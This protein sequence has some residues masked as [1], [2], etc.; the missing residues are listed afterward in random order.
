M[1]EKYFLPNQKKTSFPHHLFN[2]QG[3]YIFLVICQ[4]LFSASS[5]RARAACVFIIS[6]S[7][8]SWGSWLVKGSTNPH[9]LSWFFCFFLR[10]A[11]TALS[12]RFSL[13]SSLGARAFHAMLLSCDALQLNIICHFFLLLQHS[14]RVH[15]Y[16]RTTHE[17]TSRCAAVYRCMRAMWVYVT[18]FFS[19]SRRQTSQ[20]R[21]RCRESTFLLYI[22]ALWWYASPIAG[23]HTYIYTAPERVVLNAKRLLTCALKTRLRCQ[24]ILN[25]CM[26]L[27]GS[28]KMRHQNPYSRSSTCKT[29]YF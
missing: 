26:T 28:R 19:P 2:K 13:F 1:R 4:E 12:Y 27:D 23:A 18:D 11:R 21:L 15:K 17:Q 10:S 5:A 29:S 3:K 16:T 6:L 7:L 24:K 25:F 14:L 9:I 20:P 22:F 8:N